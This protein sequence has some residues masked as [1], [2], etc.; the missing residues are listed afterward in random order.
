MAENSSEVL[1]ILM[2]QLTALLLIIENRNGCAEKGI[3]NIGNPNNNISI[4][5][6]AELLVDRLR[7][8]HATQNMQQK[9]N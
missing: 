5:Q 8:I 3:F 2:M 4:R 6:L 7:L 1:L 9:R